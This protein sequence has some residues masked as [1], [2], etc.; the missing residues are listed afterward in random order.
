MNRA[1][2]YNTNTMIV[3]ERSGS[4]LS[5]ELE[6]KEIDRQNILL[7]LKIGIIV[8]WSEIAL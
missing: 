2:E 5:E 4:V 1:N 3:L 8:N 6:K 7:S